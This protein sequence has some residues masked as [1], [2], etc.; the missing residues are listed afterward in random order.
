MHAPTVRSTCGCKLASVR[1]PD[2][3]ETTGGDRDADPR[4]A[5]SPEEQGQMVVLARTAVC[6]AAENHVRSMP[7]P[8][9]P[10]SQ[11]KKKTPA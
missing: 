10:S 2:A 4:H 9:S 11:K 6:F 7:I 5:G 8:P 1:V 3:P